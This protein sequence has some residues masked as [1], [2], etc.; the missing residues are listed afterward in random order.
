VK[1][2]DNGLLFLAS[3]ILIVLATHNI[4]H[5]DGLV[6][7]AQPNGQHPIAGT[8]SGGAHGPT[9]AKFVQR[10]PNGA[11]GAT[12][13]A[14]RQVAPPARSST[15]AAR[16]V[17]QGGLAVSSADATF[18]SP[19]LQPQPSAGKTA[20]AEASPSFNTYSQIDVAGASDGR[21]ILSNGF[22]GNSNVQVV[23][24]TTGSIVISTPDSTFWCPG[25]NPLPICSTGGFPGDQRYYYD[26]AR[27]RWITTALWVFSSSPVPTNVVAVSQGSDPTAAWN[28]Y[29]FPSC[30]AFDNW[31]GS[32]QPHT[33]FNNQWIVVDSA[34]GTSPQGVNGAGLAVFDKEGL[35]S[36]QTLALNANWFEFV[37]PYSAPRNNPVATHAALTINN[38]EYL[39]AAAV[40]G[41]QAAVIYSY[42]EGATDSPVYVPGY[43]TVTTSFST[44]SLA[45]L[46]APGCTVCIG[47]E[48]NE[49]I[50]SSG[51]WS[52]QTGVPYVVSTMVVGDPGQPRSNQVINVATNTQTGAATALRV[53]GGTNGSGPLASEIA[54]PMSSTGIDEALI[55]YDFTGSNFFPGAKMATWNIDNNSIIDSADL[56]QGS[57]TPNSAF[58]QGRWVDFM[59]A[60]IPIQGS[61]AIVVS[62]TLGAPSTSDSQR[63]TLWT[64]VTLQPVSSPPVVAL[65]SPQRLVD[66]RSSGGPIVAGSSRC[67]TIAGRGGIPSD[68]SAVVL[69]ATA[70]DYTASGWL[71]LYPNGQSVPATSTLNFDTREYAIANNAII[72]LGTAGQVCVNAGQSGSNVILDATGYVSS[73]AGAQLALLTSPVRLVDTRSSG[74]PIPASTSRCFTITGGPIPAGAAAVL[75]N[76]TAVGYTSN[77]WLTL[78]PNGQPIAPTSTLNFD[79]HE[80]AI[81]N[82]AVIRIGTSGKVCVNA[83][84]SASNVILDATGYLTSDGVTRLPMLASPVRLVDT[85]TS[86]GVIAANTS[87][88]FT[89]TGG[90]IPANASVVIL[91][92]TGVSNTANGWLTLYPNGQ[93]LPATSTLNF[94]AHENAIANGAVIRIGTSGQVCVNAGKSASNVILDA[95][96]YELP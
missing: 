86:G 17:P 5:A 27:G 77:G 30:G 14:S 67:V 42:I 45:T 80:Y 89:I 50:H 78:Y 49:W 74:G 3:L 81:A 94:D 66:T 16:P 34:C 25:T 70:A 84:Q 72:K 46:D 52:F 15:L 71:T 53:T 79:T 37:D 47:A 92:V 57:L 1:V 7:A 39:T 68:A 38:R 12:I 73:T 83:G 63:A 24:T 26:S 21:Y 61:S 4:A 85:R 60:A 28:V 41:S 65:T 64:T 22:D 29:Q 96:G 95:T 59:D 40:V 20:V 56:Q 6:S 48:S 23:Y 55:V 31:E 44:Q 54:M 87:R 11:S 62:A 69:N 32:D 93:P 10:Q 36:G 58:D 35:Y 51:V 33:G 18:T 2:R 88:C 91:N 13:A 19:Q 9:V 75:V 8:G 76:V 82:G 43:Q 90:P